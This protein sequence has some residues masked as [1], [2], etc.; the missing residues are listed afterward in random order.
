MMRGYAYYSLI[1][2]YGPC[3]ILGDDI[4][5]NNRLSETYDYSRS[6]YNECVDYCCSELELAARYTPIGLS[7]IFFRRP[8]CGAALALIIRLQLQQAS[9]LYNGGQAAYIAFGNW[10]WTAGRANYMNQNYNEARWIMAAIACRRVI[11][12]NKYKLH[13]SPVGPS[14]P[15]RVLP[16]SVIITDPDSQNIDHYRSYSKMFTGE[17]IGNKSPEFI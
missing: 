8:S 16:V 4:L 6:A 2:S 7:P 11:E 17:T 12:M 1:Q 10:K 14:M 3:I 5:P 9:P 15:P 13:T